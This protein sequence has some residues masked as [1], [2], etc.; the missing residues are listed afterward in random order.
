M[1]SATSRL[2][3]PRLTA[4]PLAWLLILAVVSLLPACGQKTPTE[5]SADD[6]DSKKSESKRI[7]STDSK[8]EQQPDTTAAVPGPPLDAEA[9]VRRPM[10]RKGVKSWTITS[11]EDSDDNKPLPFGEQSIEFV[12][13][14]K[15][16]FRAEMAPWLRYDFN[17]ETILAGLFEGNYDAIAPDGL[18]CARLNDKAIQLWNA[19]GTKERASLEGHTISPR[20]LAFSPDGKLL[21]SGAE[22][23]VFFW[24]VDGATKVSN[25]AMPFEDYSCSA[26]SSDSK[27]L[28]VAQILPGDKAGEQKGLVSLV[29]P[30][31][32][33]VEK[34]IAL[35]SPPHKLCYSPDGKWLAAVD[36]SHH[37][38]LIETAGNKVAYTSKNADITDAQ[39]SWSSDSKRLVYATRDHNIIVWDLTEGKPLQT[40]RGHSQ[41][42][43][44]LAFAPDGQS[45]ASAGAD[46]S[47]R[48]W[49]TENGELRGVILV[50][51]KKQWL[52]VAA[53]GN[54]KGSDKVQDLF[55][56]RV[57]TDQ[58][59]KPIL[60]QT[61]SEVE[62]KYNIV[63]K[64]DQVRLS[65]K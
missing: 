39:P 10:I 64:P 52:V 46:N 12:P 2:A 4:R 33:K 44:A 35:V 24:K 61:P 49:N 34:T 59:F 48:V 9:Y 7:T 56:Y 5:K 19:G 27:T 30:G 18:T 51:P 29:A 1:T 50:F 37:L 17:Q 32:A 23:A 20:L 28:A 16:V 11:K 42:V 21:A 25:S 57:Q 14:G 53:N 15:L 60:N 62:A 3:D 26:W 8:H 22:D 31:T 63:N 47:L 43:K 40:C 36:W 65:G 45:V 13:G 41:P 55:V 38:V 54:F 58:K 6:K